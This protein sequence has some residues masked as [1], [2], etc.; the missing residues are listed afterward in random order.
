MKISEATGSDLT[1]TNAAIAA[2]AAD[3]T[4]SSLVLRRSAIE[5]TNPG[6]AVT[7]QIFQVVIDLRTGMQSDFSDVWVTDGD[8]GAMLD[9]WIDTT[10]DAAQKAILWF[11]V[12]TIAAAST[13]TVNLHWGSPDA[14][15]APNGYGIFDYWEPVEN[16]GNGTWTRVADAVW[17]HTDA[18]C[19]VGACFGTV[20]MD[21]STY[22]Y[23]YTE[24]VQTICV[25]TS[26][27][28]VTWG[29]RTEIFGPTVAWESVNTWDPCVWKEG[30]TWYMLYTGNATTNAIGLATASNPLGPWTKYASN[31]VME[32]TAATWDS[33]GVENYGVIKVGSTYYLYYNTLSG[34][35]TSRQTGIAT[36]TDLITWTK[37]AANPI[38]GYSRQQAMPFKWGDYYYL[39]IVCW[40]YASDQAC[41]ALYRDT[42]PT[43]YPDDRE[44]VRIVAYPK[45][46]STWD[47]DD[48]DCPS[49]LHD[50]IT[51]DSFPGDGKIRMYVSGQY[52]YNPEAD[53][54]WATGLYY[55]D[56][57]TDLEPVAESLAKS[58]TDNYWWDHVETTVAKSDASYKID[59]TG[60]AAIEYW[61]SQQEITITADCVIESWM[62]ATAGGG[63]GT[64]H[65]SMYCWE[66]FS[67]IRA[68][69]GLNI[70]TLKFNKHNGTAYADTTTT[71]A[72]D[73]WYLFRMVW[74]QAAK[75]FD[76]YV[77][78]ENMRMVYK[79][80]AIQT[81]VSAQID[82][83]GWQTGSGYA[84]TAYFD[85]L[86]VRQPESTLVTRFT[87]DEYLD[88]PMVAV[89]QDITDAGVAAHKVATDAQAAIWTSTK[90][91]YLDASVAGVPALAAAAVGARTSDGKTYDK[92]L[93]VLLAA[94]AGKADYDANTG[95]WT[96]KKVDGLTT[97]FTVT[98]GTDAGDRTVISIP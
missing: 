69:V 66:N 50:S 97:C 43:F 30:S 89:K 18:G 82:R 55:A 45:E 29:N 75:T 93:E 60:A 58:A 20:W 65:V 86:R 73:T 11:K 24:D 8:T 44:F 74:H 6:T 49:I 33:T 37:D 5:I 21:G 34:V 92:I 71:C 48:L 16:H 14:V 76:Y 51:R 72:V 15:H 35:G 59:H 84:G 94:A 52:E 23:F 9:Y 19:T 32:G 67:T 42:A 91:G 41:I 10:I 54:Y 98:L 81:N 90:A 87:T 70:G 7:D 96:V 47:S 77:F 22:Y 64:R 26:T 62:R 36:S 83:V 13:K 4:D 25:V 79:E 12:P 57:D 78:D 88:V 56:A 40:R 1:A 68:M 38:F 28:G 63:T 39:L 17:D 3:L 27:D 61:S 53:Y 46:S 85:S 80:M 2:I 95:V 31:P